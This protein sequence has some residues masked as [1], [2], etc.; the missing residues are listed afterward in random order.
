MKKDEHALR[1]TAS[2]FLASDRNGL[3]QQIVSARWQFL[4]ALRRQVPE[5]Y[6]RLRDDVYP[7]F[8]RLAKPGYWRT[9]RSF[10]MWQS[11]WDSDRQL[12]PI[13][14]E[15]ARRFN[16]E[17]EVWILEGALQ[18]LSNWNKFPHGLENLEIR[19][20]WKPICVP[21]LVWYGEHPFHF[22]DAGWDPT[23]ISFPGWRVNVGK[24][25]AAAMQQHRQQMQA[26]IKE[27]G[28]LPAVVR[29]SEEH[30]DWLALYQCA[31]ASLESIVK[32][33][34]YGD[35]TTISKGM[36]R[37]AKLAGIGIRGRHRKLKSR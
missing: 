3:N 27:R 34:R 25:F 28:G 18:T 15:W 23:L 5:F 9:G 1:L 35:R 10:G 21:G 20:F 7:A 8:M 22:E 30:F 26:L 11:R 6:E 14:M 13:L 19:G 4:L 2:E 24:R 17:E 36:H 37:A 16:V 12:T 31:N 29:S 33:A 32:R